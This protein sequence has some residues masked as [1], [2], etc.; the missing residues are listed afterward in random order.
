MNGAK[1]ADIAELLA[2]K[3]LAM[4]LRYAHLAPSKLHGVVSLLN[5]TDTRTDTGQ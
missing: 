4:T 3:G 2:H 1:L 5:S